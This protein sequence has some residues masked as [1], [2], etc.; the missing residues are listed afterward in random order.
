MEP[1]CS[2]RVSDAA[3]VELLHEIVATPSLS[4]REGD[5]AA[6]LVRRM[7]ALGLRAHVDE[8][9]NAVGVR[10]DDDAPRTIVLLGHMDTVPGDIPVRIEEGV[11]HGRG[12][13]DAKG[14]LAA[15]VVAAA[16][17]ELPEGVRLVVAGAVEEETATSRGARAIARA[18]SPE[19]CIIAEPSGVD[20]VTI[21]Y[22]GRVVVRASFE[23]ENAHTAGPGGSAMDRL[24]AWWSRVLEH[25]RRLNEQRGPDAGI[26]DLV[27]S[28][29]RGWEHRQDGLVDGAT[30]VGAFRMPTWIDSRRMIELCNEADPSARIGLL[31]EG[32][33]EAVRS[34]RTDRVA[35]AL[36][37]AIRSRGR[38]PVLKLKTGTCD[39]NVVD[40]VWRC[41]I[42]AYGPGDSSLDHTPRER[43]TIAEYLES[44]RVL[45]I[46]LE[47]LASVP[48]TA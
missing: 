27:Q 42:A 8:T 14:P 13:V 47:S 1:E 31:F 36:S 5:V 3:A 29:I 38:R 44:V 35:V 11:L 34:P 7:R 20:G 30:L 16:R 25:V 33:E 46:A 17:C 12:S 15:C 22:K 40:P 23:Q 39:M 48:V 18:Y 43:L 4:R 41:D 45:T 24:H 21:G 10:G 26:F 37:G 28:T 9:G 6:L 32:R 19:A 2:E